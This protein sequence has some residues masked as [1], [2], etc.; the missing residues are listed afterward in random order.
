MTPMAAG[1]LSFRGYSLN[2]DD[3]LRPTVVEEMGCGESAPA[4]DDKFCQAG[5]A[6]M[7]K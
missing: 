7:G 2:I 1:Y 3:M 6:A 5:I 4:N